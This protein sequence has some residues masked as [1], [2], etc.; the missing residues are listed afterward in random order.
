[1]IS[2]RP[3]FQRQTSRKRQDRAQDHG[4][5]PPASLILLPQASSSLFLSVLS[6]SFLDQAPFTWVSK[7]LNLHPYLLYLWRICQDV[8]FDLQLAPYL[9]VQSG[10]LSWSGPWI[11]RVRLPWC[12][13]PLWAVGACCSGRTEGSYNAAGAIDLLALPGLPEF[14]TGCS[15]YAVCL[16][17]SFNPIV[18]HAFEELS[19]RSP[20]RC[21]C[22]G[23]AGLN[24]QAWDSY[25]HHILFVPWLCWFLL[26]IW[27]FTLWKCCQHC[28]VAI[29]AAS[30][31][32]RQTLLN[33][34]WFGSW[35]LVLGPFLL[36]RSSFSSYALS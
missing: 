12:L 28:L 4:C 18:F 24:T 6:S 33:D 16:G 3:E 25:A 31:W 2:Y 26:E 30:P 34:P 8:S 20:R 17:Q 22:L 5:Q 27:A 13:E 10:Q 14:D 35:D 7:W 29:P 15:N 36:A 11:G 32:H 21:C 19:Q 23:F 9:V 1:M